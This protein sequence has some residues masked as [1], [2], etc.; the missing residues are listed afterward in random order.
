MFEN[1]RDYVTLF[2]VNVIYEKGKLNVS[3]VEAVWTKHIA[4]TFIIIYQYIINSSEACR[5]PLL[6]YDEIM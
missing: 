5:E 2:P 4:M 6:S 1:Y 3:K